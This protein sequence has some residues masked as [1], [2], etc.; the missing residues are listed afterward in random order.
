MDFK[1]A[2]ELLMH[3]VKKKIFLSQRLCESVKSSLAKQPLKIVK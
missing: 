2:Q 3:S 1:N